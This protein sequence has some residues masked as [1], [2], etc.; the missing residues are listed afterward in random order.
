MQSESIRVK[1]EIVS[2]KIVSTLYNVDYIL[3][4]P[5]EGMYPFSLVCTSRVTT[6]S[7]Q[8]ILCQ[9]PNDDVNSI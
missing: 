7:I 6:M 5:P 3:Y 8:F 9:S 4:Q 2:V 1:A